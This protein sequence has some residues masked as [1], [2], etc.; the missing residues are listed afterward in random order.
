MAP[1]SFKRQRRGLGKRSAQQWLQDES[2]AADAA[3]PTA[4]W[5][6]SRGEVVPSLPLKGARTRPTAAGWGAQA[7]ICA[8]KPTRRRRNAPALGHLRGKPP[9]AAALV[10][11]VTHGFQGCAARG[12]A[13]G[14]R[15]GRSSWARGPEAAIT[16]L[17]KDTRPGKT[18][19]AQ[20]GASIIR[21]VWGRKKQP[22]HNL[23]AWI[24][25]VLD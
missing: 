25:S 11:E 23:T 9:A 12:E 21:I 6:F 15:G 13:V 20:T 5:E 17:G 24:P 8:G 4:S 2:A 18:Q 14:S 16:A 10:V 22:R 7:A 1:G 19:Q 3:H